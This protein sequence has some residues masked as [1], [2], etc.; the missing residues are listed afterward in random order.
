M[1]L[2]PSLIHPK[3]W[4]LLM[5][6]F[7]YGCTVQPHRPK[8]TTAAGALTAE[9]MKQWQV[10]G[11][12]GFRSPDQK[13]SAN[14]RW[15]QTPTTFEMRLSGPFGQ[16]A[17]V[18]QGDGDMV[19]FKQGDHPVRYGH[20][21]AELMETNMG[22]SLPMEHLLYWARG[23]ALP[24]AEN[25]I[26]Q[27]NDNGQISRM[28]EGPWT[29]EYNRYQPVTDSLVLPQKITVTKEPLKLTIIF[30]DWNPQSAQ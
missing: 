17:A 21:L 27:R 10:T 18:I 7:L 24:E 23:L 1:M 13:G 4:V 20:S 28:T 29:L 25:Q 16:G 2:Q 22:W 3:I 15:Q 11:K 26:I 5:L 30:S 6:S 9:T 12:V 8:V 19:T 14:F